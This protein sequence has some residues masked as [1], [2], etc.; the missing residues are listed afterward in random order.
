MTRGRYTVR[1]PVRVRYDSMYLRQTTFSSTPL[2]SLSVFVYYSHVV[3]SSILLP[4]KVNNS[5]TILGVQNIHH[6]V[7]EECSLY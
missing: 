5:R 3:L 6:I 7:N 4:S 1:D 2:L